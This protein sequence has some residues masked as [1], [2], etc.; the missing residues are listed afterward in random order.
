MVLAGFFGVPAGVQ[1]VAMG[2]VGVMPALFVI[3]G[4]M[5]LGCFAMMFGGLLVMFGRLGVMLRS[6]MHGAFL[7]LVLS[8][9]PTTPVSLFAHFENTVKTAFSFDDSATLRDFTQLR[10]RPPGIRWR[11]ELNL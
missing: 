11:K 8:D 3:A 7:L 9:V 4:L 5:M 6:F 10:H 2:D 1:R